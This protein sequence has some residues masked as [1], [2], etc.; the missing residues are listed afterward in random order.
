MGDKDKGVPKLMN[1]SSIMS[2][3]ILIGIRITFDIRETKTCYD[4]FRY[5][6]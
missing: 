4:V 3:M 1:S 6:H 2:A 5:S